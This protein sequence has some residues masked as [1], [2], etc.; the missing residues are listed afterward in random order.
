MVIPPLLGNPYNGYMNPYYWVDDHPLLYGNN[1]SLDPST[2]LNHQHFGGEFHLEDGLPGR[3]HVSVVIGSPPTYFSH[4]VQP[5]GSGVPHPILFQ[6][7]KTNHGPRKTTETSWEVTLEV[8]PRWG[9][10]HSQSLRVYN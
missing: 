9:V 10:F 7:T 4:E 2:Y 6:G 3:V 8:V 5:F 1:G